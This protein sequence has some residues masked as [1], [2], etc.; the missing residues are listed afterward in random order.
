MKYLPT[1]NIEKKAEDLL[2]STES[3]RLPIPVEII[4]HRL[5]VVVDTAPLGEDI[6]G[7]LVVKDEIGTIGVNQSH[8]PVRQ[9]FTIAHELGH[10][11]LHRELSNLFIDKEYTA[12]R[13]SK[14]SQGEDRAEIQANRFAAALLMPREMVMR[15]IGGPHGFDFGDEKTLDRL[16]DKFQVSVQA[17]SIR[18]SNL[19]VFD[20]D[21]T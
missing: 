6:S 15:E 10:Y 14:S 13:D 1:K 11:V 2:R 9:R 19:G 21:V 3:M 5:G 17:M 12:F 7:V 4:A 20:L 16:A 18:L 8:S